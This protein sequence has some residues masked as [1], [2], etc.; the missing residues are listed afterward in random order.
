MKQNYLQIVWGPYEVAIDFD[1]VPSAL[2]KRGHYF[3]FAKPFEVEEE[4]GR[5]QFPGSLRH[6]KT[7]ARLAVGTISE[8][9][10]S[11]TE[12]VE[13]FR[14]R[15]ATSR[16]LLWLGIH[17][18]DAQR[19]FPIFALGDELV[20]RASSCHLCLQALGGNREFRG[21]TLYDSETFV[22]YAHYGIG[23]FLFEG[24]C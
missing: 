21:L 16:E 5:P 7:F 13:D 22:R 19:L 11:L 8:P 20:V 23:G 14:I 2:I 6:G 1:A 3:A 18:P 15:L 17:F 24:L 9:I 4:D 12:L 10:S